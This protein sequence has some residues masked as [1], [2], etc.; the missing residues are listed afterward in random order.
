MEDSINKIALLALSEG[1]WERAQ[2]LLFENAKKNPCHESFN[3]LGYFLITEGLLCKNGRTRNADKLGHSYL[4]RAAQ[5]RESA[6][7]YCALAKWLA[8]ELRV[9]RSEGKK[10]LLVLSRAYLEK[11]LVLSPS[12]E[13][14]YNL[15]R[16]LHWLGEDNSVV[17]ER[18]RPLVQRMPCEE[19]ALLYLS[20][21]CQC[22]LLD[23]GMAC[24]EQY[25]TYLDQADVLMF[26]ARFGLYEQGYALCEAVCRRFAPGPFLDAA[27]VEC[28]VQVKQYDAVRTFIEQIKARVD[29][30]CD[31]DVKGWRER[32]LDA[33]TKWSAY[34]KKLILESF[35]FPH[36]FLDQCCYFDCPIHG[37][38]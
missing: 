27:I 4:L 32:V 20:L 28:C 18:L 35:Q 30:Y 2:Q 8:L 19:S 16:T 21:I 17:I 36:P 29:R 23:E 26:Y 3:N 12:D 33:S 6:K 5:L 38:C 25:A 31:Y 34:R 15:L 1:D 13:T 11:A 24:I 9:K 14:E 10:E 22:G 37:N 7:N